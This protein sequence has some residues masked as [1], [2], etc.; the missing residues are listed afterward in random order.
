MADN[1]NMNALTI[2]MIKRLNIMFNP[3]KVQNTINVI[4]VLSIAKLLW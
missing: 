3:E 4:N 2:T 1:I